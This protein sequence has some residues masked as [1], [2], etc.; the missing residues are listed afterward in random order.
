MEDMK[1]L[2]LPQEEPI[3]FIASLGLFFLLALLAFLPFSRDIVDTLR[4][5]F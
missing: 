5:L 2:G 4:S 3:D 1:N